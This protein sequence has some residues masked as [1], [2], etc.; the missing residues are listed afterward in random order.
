MHLTLVHVLV[1]LQLHLV[2]PILLKVCTDS[3]QDELVKIKCCLQKYITPRAIHL[4]T[5]CN[6]LSWPTITFY[7]CRHSQGIDRVGS[8]NGYI[9]STILLYLIKTVRNLRF[10][11]YQ[12]C[13][14]KSWDSKET[15]T[16]SVPQEISREE[17]KRFNE[18]KTKLTVIKRGGRLKFSI[19]RPSTKYTFCQKKTDVMFVVQEK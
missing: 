9:R 10:Q 15:D 19:Y 7:T 18:E 8:I 2:Q 17:G 12:V 6:T 1:L 3:G 13:S 5:C 16:W 11:I 4:C 14:I